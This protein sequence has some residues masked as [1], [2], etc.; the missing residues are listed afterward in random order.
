MLKFLKKDINSKFL[1]LFLN[2]ILLCT[3]TKTNLVSLVS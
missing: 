3:K 1:F 2:L